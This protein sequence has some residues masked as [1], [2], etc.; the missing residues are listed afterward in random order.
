MSADP[1]DPGHL[2]WRVSSKCESGACVKVAGDG[3]YVFVA[4]TDMPDGPISRYTRAE[5]RQFLAGV[6]LGEFDDFG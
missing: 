1:S 6:K 3:D 4:N 2:T 5:W